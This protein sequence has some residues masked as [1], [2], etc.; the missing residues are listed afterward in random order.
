MYDH[1]R[2]FLNFS[3]YDF[4]YNNTRN[5]LLVYYVDF[6]ITNFF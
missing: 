6:Y 5:I 2:I 1:Q 3:M 4:I